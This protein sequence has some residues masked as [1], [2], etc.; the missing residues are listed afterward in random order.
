MR[1]KQLIIGCL[2]FFSFFCTSALAELKPLNAKGAYFG[3]T[4]PGLTPKVFAPGLVSTTNWEQNGVFTPD[5]NEYYFLREVELNGQLQ[6]QFVVL[7]NIDNQWHEEVISGR[8]GQPSISPDGQTMHLG[9]R[10]KVRSNDTWSDI[11]AL[12]APFD[13]FRIM[14]MASS[15]KGTWVFDE[16]TRDGKG[17]LR[18]SQLVNGKRSAPKPFPKAINTGQWNAH[19]FIAP[20]ESYLIWDG[21]RDSDVRNADLFISFRQPDGSWGEAIKFGDDINTPTS[22]AGARVSPDGKYL[23]FNR[24]VGYFDWTSPEGKTE[25]IPNTDVFWVDAKIIDELRLKANAR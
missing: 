14:R 9:K 22:E 15:R 8:V 3:Q 21:Q 6:Q 4:P 16:A 12:K 11:K 1:N 25:T 24:R 2:S 18:F 5:M 20:D 7:K 10:Y 19:P 13:A 17:Q 23:F